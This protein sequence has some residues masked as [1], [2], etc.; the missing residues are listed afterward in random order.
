MSRAREISKILTSDTDLVTTAELNSAVEAIDLSEYLTVSSASST[1]L[2]YPSASSTYA[3]ITGGTLTTPTITTPNITNGTIADVIVKGLEEDVNIV[4]SAATGTINLNVA[5][6]SILYYTSN[7]TANHT[8]NI[9][10]DSSNTLNS[11]IAVGDAITVAWMNTNGATPNYPTV[12]Q[13]DSN[14]VSPIWQGGTAP[15]GGNA[16]SVDVY[17]LTII[18]TEVTPTYVVLA[19]QTQFKA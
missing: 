1:Y 6:S 19:S 3:L 8:L 12:Y 7:A 18:K 17:T 4:A 16:S 11:K 5:D 10:Y 9:R 14:S 2:T 15:T 13:V